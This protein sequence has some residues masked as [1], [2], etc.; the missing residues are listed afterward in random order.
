MQFALIQT[1]VSHV[2]VS[3]GSEV[4]ELVVMIS[5]N[6]KVVCTTA[7]WQQNVAT[8]LVVSPVNVMKD[9]KVMVLPAK[10]LLKRS[11]R[12]LNVRTTRLNLKLMVF[13]NASVIQDIS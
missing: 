5:M 7:I 6:A 13:W 10:T 4:M 11:E 3:M 9:G 2:N 12:Y 1:A 8:S